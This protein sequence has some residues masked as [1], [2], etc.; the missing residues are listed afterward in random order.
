[1]H[2]GKATAAVCPVGEHMVRQK[3]KNK[4]SEHFCFVLS[5]FIV[6]KSIVFTEKSLTLPIALLQVSG[7]RF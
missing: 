6:R 4:L 5:Y 7:I 3:I 2:E 1:M